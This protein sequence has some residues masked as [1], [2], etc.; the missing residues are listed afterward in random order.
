ASARADAVVTRRQLFPPKPSVRPREIFFGPHHDGVAV[1]LAD[2]GAAV[3]S[4]TPQRSANASAPPRRLVIIR[5][6]LYWGFSY[7]VD[8]HVIVGSGRRDAGRAAGADALHEPAPV[9]GVD[10]NADGKRCRLDELTGGI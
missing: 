5:A 3:T 2:E 10:R 7:D 1:V 8:G 4:T 6:L 9:D